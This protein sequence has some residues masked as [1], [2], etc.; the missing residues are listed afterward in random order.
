MPRWLGWATIVIGVSAAAGPL[1]GLAI[2][3][4]AL[5]VLVVS[6]MLLQ[7]NA[8]VPPTSADQPPTPAANTQVAR[9]FCHRPDHTD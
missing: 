2:P 4:E 5:W 8:L 9:S 1:I 7:R 6:F 3:L